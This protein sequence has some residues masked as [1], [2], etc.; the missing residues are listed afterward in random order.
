MHNDESS[1][2]KR[3][4]ER[5]YYVT[6]FQD[7]EPISMCVNEEM[8]AK[9]KEEERKNG[10]RGEAD[11]DY[12]LFNRLERDRMAFERAYKAYKRKRFESL[13]IAFVFLVVMFTT[14]GIY[15]IK[16]ILK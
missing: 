9:I 8:F 6:V 4:R 12:Y 1:K 3:K 2:E 5:M 10:S 13:A 14:M 15:L 16:I 11:T 7:G